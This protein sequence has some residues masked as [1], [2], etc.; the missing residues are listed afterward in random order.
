MIGFL[1]H[2]RDVQTFL[3]AESFFSILLLCV[4]RVW[5]VMCDVWWI[6]VIYACV[7]WCDVWCVWS[8]WSAYARYECVCRSYKCVS[9]HVPILRAH[10]LKQSIIT[11]TS[12][13][14]LTTPTRT[15]F[16]LRRLAL[17]ALWRARAASW[18]CSSA[19]THCKH[20]ALHTPCEHMSEWHTHTCNHK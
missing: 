13:K 15:F 8:A 6:C 20:H 12:L 19:L 4:C 3:S 2:L 14:N 11:H 9:I 16:R 17:R 1:F 18:R 10:T 7:W 5:C